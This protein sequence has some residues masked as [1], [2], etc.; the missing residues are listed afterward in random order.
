MLREM[1]AKSSFVKIDATSPVCRLSLYS[2][3]RLSDP[4]QSM[5]APNTLH[6]HVEK[7]HLHHD[8]FL[9]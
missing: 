4:Y 8:S 5:P 3:P 1:A 2:R 7:F 9:E 6:L